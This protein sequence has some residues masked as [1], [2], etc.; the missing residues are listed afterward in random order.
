MF[1]S[2]LSNQSNFVSTLINSARLNENDHH[3][4]TK[5]SKTK[6][7]F[8]MLSGGIGSAAALSYVLQ[9]GRSPTLIYVQ[10][11]FTGLVEQK[12]KN[13]VINIASNSRKMDGKPLA[14][15]NNQTIQPWLNVINGSEIPKKEESW[16]RFVLLVARV[17]DVLQK[18]SDQIQL[19]FG[20]LT[21]EQKRTLILFKDK[22]SIFVP[23]RTEKDAI[24]QIHLVDKLDHSY[25]MNGCVKNMQHPGKYPVYILVVNKNRILVR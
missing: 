3:L 13:A 10:D 21:D 15:V 23:I 1:Q 7:P 2:F 4:D 8:V 22:I 9:S 24:V 11:I 16:Y 6:T 20:P 19:V 14:S 25:R 18:R 17:I 12:R 5:L